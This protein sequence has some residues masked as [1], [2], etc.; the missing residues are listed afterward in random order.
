MKNNSSSNQKPK[1]KN[2]NKSK[3][4]SNLISIKAKSKRKLVIFWGLGETGTW[5]DD[6]NTLKHWISCR[7]LKY[8]ETR[9]SS[10]TLLGCCGGGK[11]VYGF[12]SLVLTFFCWT[13]FLNKSLRSNLEYGNILDRRNWKKVIISIYRKKCSRCH[14]FWILEETYPSFRLQVL[15]PFQALSSS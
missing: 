5:C 8:V 1:K 15:D 14:T 10:L 6:N 12:F 9:S 11:G 13:F 2:L 7:N 4:T 3:A